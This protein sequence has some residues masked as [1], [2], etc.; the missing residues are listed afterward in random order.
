MSRVAVLFGKD[1][2]PQ[3]VRMF[4]EGCP[5]PEPTWYEMSIDQYTE[6]TRCLNY[7]LPL[8]EWFEPVKKEAE[9]EKP[10]IEDTRD[11]VQPVVVKRGPGR[12]RKIVS[13]E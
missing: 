1:N 3:S 4:P 9:P 2:W 11:D 13:P 7:K 10:V 5:N 8:P 6:L 12:P